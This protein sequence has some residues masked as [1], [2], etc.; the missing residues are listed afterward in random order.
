MTPPLGCLASLFGVRER[1]AAPAPVPAPRGNTVPDALPVSAKRYFFS[2]AEHAF[3]RS[4]EEAIAGSGYRAFP[5]VRLNDLF[6]IDDPAQR[7]AVLGRL[8][9]KHVDFVLVDPAQ[10]FRPVLAIE[11]DG[12]SHQRAEQQYRDAVKDVIFRSG[13][14]KLVRLPSRAYS[15]P[16]LRERLAREGLKLRA[17]GR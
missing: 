17:G 10:G 16:E 15:A 12:A 1:P 3:F 13:G 7:G 11:L 14:L 4:L 5:N 2:R 6:L 8:R 9:D